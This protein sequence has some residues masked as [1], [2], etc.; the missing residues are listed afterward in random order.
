M[1]NKAGQKLWQYI[2]HAYKVLGMARYFSF[3]RERNKY[4][5]SASRQRQT[6][7]ART[8]NDLLERVIFTPKYLFIFL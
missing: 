7:L 8:Q 1:L 5:V 2:L 3:T 4:T 6:H